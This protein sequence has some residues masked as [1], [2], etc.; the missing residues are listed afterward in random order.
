MQSSREQVHGAHRF[1]VSEHFVT[2]CDRVTF[3]DW[4]LGGK[5]VKFRTAAVNAISDEPVAKRQDYLLL[6]L[7]EIQWKKCTF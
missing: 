6:F 2:V 5:E 1:A 3:V 4:E 7:T